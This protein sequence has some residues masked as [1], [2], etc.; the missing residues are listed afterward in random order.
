M[1]SN[2]MDDWNITSW[3]RKDRNQ[4]HIGENVDNSSCVSRR[5]WNLQVFTTVSKNLHEST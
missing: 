4:M 1:Q 5:I 3:W 2:R